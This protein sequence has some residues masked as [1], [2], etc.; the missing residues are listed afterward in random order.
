M[1]TEKMIK[2]KCSFPLFLPV[3]IIK[4]VIVEFSIKNVLRS[5]FSSICRYLLIILQLRV[6]TITW[7]DVNHLL[8]M[9]L[10][11]LADYCS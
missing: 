4:I 6:H 3:T 8:P 7:P 9:F 1:N 11:F 10:P 5:Y 2:C